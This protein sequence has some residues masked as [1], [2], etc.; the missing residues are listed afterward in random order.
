MYKEVGVK[1]GDGL[2]LMVCIEM[3][4]TSHPHVTQPR[5]HFPPTM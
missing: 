4:T 5:Q 2:Y 1:D 3:I